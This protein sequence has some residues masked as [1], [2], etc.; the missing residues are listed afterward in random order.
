VDTHPSSFENENERNNCPFIGGIN[1]S[2]STSEARITPDERPQKM[3]KN[4]IPIKQSWLERA[5]QTHNYHVGKCK[6]DSKWTVAHTAKNLHR[7]L[8]SISEDLLIVNWLKTH[9]NK[10]RQFRHQY[11]ALAFIRS[12]KKRILEPYA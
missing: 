1:S 5:I 3:G 10:I 11:E 6:S 9:E 7:S 12:N 4:G 8:G 2:L